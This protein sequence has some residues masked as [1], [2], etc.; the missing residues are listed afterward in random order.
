MARPD[1]HQERWRRS[2][3]RASRDAQTPARKP[4]S[5]SAQ[6]AQQFRLR[7]LEESEWHV[8]MQ[9]SKENPTLTLRHDVKARRWQV[10]FSQLPVGEQLLLRAEG[11]L[12]SLSKA[13]KGQDILTGD[14][15]FDDLV[16]I[17]GDPIEVLALFNE[18]CRERT[19]DLI[20]LG[21]VLRAKTLSF[22]LHDNLPLGSRNL[23][24]L[25]RA[26][27]LRSG[28]RMT[29][30]S[31][32][33]RLQSNIRREENLK[34]KLR[35]IAALASHDPQTLAKIRLPNLDK[36][37]LSTRVQF[38]TAMGSAGTKLQIQLAW[39]ERISLK[40]RAQL[41]E[42]LADQQLGTEALPLFESALAKHRNDALG[43]A[44]QRLLLDM[45]QTE[46]DVFEALGAS[47]LALLFEVA[48]L[49]EKLRLAERLGAIGD[50]SA[51]PSLLPHTSGLFVNGK[52][53]AATRRAVAAIEGR[54]GAVRGNLSLSPG[55]PEAGQLSVSSK[56]SAG[57]LA[58]TSTEDEQR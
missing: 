19:M 44:A 20:R 35:Q 16:F 39:D 32:S 29:A 49:A 56:D 48:P 3:D 37:P 38:A 15:A 36:H 10:Q 42:N 5:P 6:M 13:F 55:G 11:G 57:R 50:A 40:D 58:L 30:R 33:K 46:P 26:I 8:L 47:S 54:A 7:V 51:L 24:L 45:L 21:A 23:S 17:E 43:S 12:Q 52:L 41:L 9:D 34:V 53:K 27:T 1:P 25:Q 22:Q 2:Q 18:K 14:Q 31:L 28:M 4:K